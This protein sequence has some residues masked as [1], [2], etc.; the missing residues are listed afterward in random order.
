MRDY[1]CRLG[2][3]NCIKFTITLTSVLGFVCHRFLVAQ[4]FSIEPKG[5]EHKW[6]DT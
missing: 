3:E 2:I 4:H 1:Q 6:L 5:Y